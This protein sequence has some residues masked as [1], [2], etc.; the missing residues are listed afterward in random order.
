VSEVADIKAVI[1]HSIPFAYT[2]KPPTIE[3]VKVVPI[4]VMEVVVCEAVPV[5]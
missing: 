5:M 1:K 4:P 2:I 3:E